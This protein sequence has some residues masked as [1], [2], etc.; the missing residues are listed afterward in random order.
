MHGQPPAHIV[1]KTTVF[2]NLSAQYPR[3]LLGSQ[4]TTPDPGEEIRVFSTT[5]S[6]TLAGSDSDAA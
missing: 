2:F 5:L 1:S 4:P 6:P 3:W